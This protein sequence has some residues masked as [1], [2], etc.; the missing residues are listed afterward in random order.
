MRIKGSSNI[1]SKEKYYN[2]NM[3]HNEWMETHIQT[4]SYYLIDYI[5]I[6]KCRS[7]YNKTTDE[8]FDDVSQW[9]VELTNKTFT[10]WWW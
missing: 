2:N 4:W 3:V 8:L 6:Y 5:Y 1:T 7:T 9:I 10:S